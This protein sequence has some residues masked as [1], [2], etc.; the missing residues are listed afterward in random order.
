MGLWPCRQVWGWAK[1]AAG[2][3][4]VVGMIH[5]DMWN[6]AEGWGDGQEQVDC[7]R[8]YHCFPVAATPAQEGA[9]LLA[10]EKVM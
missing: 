5:W 6:Q 10:S 3:G 9:E 8:A 7:Y 2:P 1:A 4:A